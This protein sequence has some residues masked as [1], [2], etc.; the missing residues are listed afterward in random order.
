MKQFSIDEKFLDHIQLLQL[1][2]KDNVAGLFGGNHKSKN[3]GSSCEFADY[4]EYIPG[5]DISKIDW[6]VFAR[7][8]K[9]FLKLFLDERQMHT[10]I[11]IDAS[12]S[13]GYYDKPKQALQLAAILAYLSIQAMDK[14]SIYYIHGHHMNEVFT[15]IVGKDAYFNEVVKLNDI[16]F[17]GDSFISE[18][19]IPTMIGYGDGKSIIISDFLTENN[20]ENA[21]DYLRSKKRDV[22]C[23]QILATEETSPLS[24]GKTIFYDDENTQNFYKDNIDKHVLIAY[25][26]AID[27][28]TSKIRNFCLSREADYALVST[29]DSLVEIFLKKLVDL[30]VVK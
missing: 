1:A 26:K 2:I 16:N 11:Y 23:L 8:D 24:R 10:R 3:Y 17:V 15:N 13:M 22:L 9:L 4:R 7:F 29:K 19:I 28:V 21:I 20:Y 27:Y 14:V 30:G 18:A 5:D 25:Q 6:N 12:A